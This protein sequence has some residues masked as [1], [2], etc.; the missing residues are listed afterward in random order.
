[1]KSKITFTAKNL[2]QAAQFASSLS[3]D[4]RWTVTI[5]ESDG[6]FYVLAEG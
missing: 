4:R 5:T 6:W 1:M 3:T 2:A